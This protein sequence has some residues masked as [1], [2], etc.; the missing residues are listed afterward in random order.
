MTPCLKYK[1]FY[2]NDL[3]LLLIYFNYQT[4][5]LTNGIVLRKK[6]DPYDSE[7]KS[8]YLA[9]GLAQLRIVKL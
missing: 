2:A 8:I 7:L 6:W 5:R 4:D 3:K 1:Y 9:C